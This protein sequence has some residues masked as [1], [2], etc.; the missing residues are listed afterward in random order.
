MYIIIGKNM[1][2]ETKK[3]NGDLPHKSGP[4]SIPPSPF[5]KKVIV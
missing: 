4:S 2:G 3:K 5:K 1:N